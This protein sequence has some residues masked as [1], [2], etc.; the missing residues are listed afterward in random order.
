MCAGAMGV[1]CRKLARRFVL[2]FCDNARL[3]DLESK[4]PRLSIV[5]VMKLEAAAAYLIRG[6]VETGERLQ[7][8]LIEICCSSKKQKID[9]RRLMHFLIG[10]SSSQHLNPPGSLQR[11]LHVV[12]ACQ[13]RQQIA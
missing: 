11:V 1:R 4:H 3:V 5:D 7:R 13:V 8:K 6:W 9:K 10:K 12:Y 2:R